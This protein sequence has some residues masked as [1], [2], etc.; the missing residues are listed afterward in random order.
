MPRL[1]NEQE[2]ELVRRF[3]ILDLTE[4][5]L[6]DFDQKMQNDSEFKEQVELY[7]NVDNLIQQLENRNTPPPSPS[8]Q[9]NKTTRNKLLFIIASLIALLG[10]ASFLIF[11]QQ[12][13]K[14]I[15]QVVAD[16]N[17]YTTL[18]SNDMLRGDT[19]ITNNTFSLE[20][21]K[22]FQS[23]QKAIDNNN[24][25]AAIPLLNQLIE[26]SKDFSAQELALWWLTNIYLQKGDIQNAKLTLKKIINNP[27]FNSSHK[28]TEF[29]NQL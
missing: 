1:L 12:N 2:L 3:Y 10:I 20:D 8:L 26:T 24:S 4:S 23:S 9:Q 22:I 11:S 17:T 14:N 27:E 6:N 28:A 19:S 18:M 29:L 13:S 15:D 25:D 16:C 7:Q 21:Q 5:E